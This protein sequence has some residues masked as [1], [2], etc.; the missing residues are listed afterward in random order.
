M[1]M[2]TNESKTLEEIK[3]LPPEEA[4][5][6]LDN[7]IADNLENDEAFSL[8][9]MK[10]WTLNHRQQAINDYLAAIKINPDSKAKLALQ[11]ANSILDYYC[12]D[13]LN[14]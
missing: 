7:I 6:L 5:A 11:Y 12:K 14:P 2:G 10:H 3:K 8:R 1:I 13:L 4:I 9:G